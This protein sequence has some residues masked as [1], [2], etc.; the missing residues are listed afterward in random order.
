MRTPTL[1]QIEALMAFVEAGTVSRAA[2]ALRISQPAASKLLITLE[3]DTQLQLFE[4]E[5]R[6]LTLTPQ[7]MQLYQEIHRVFA[8]VEQIARAVDA[9]RQ[10]ERGRLLIGVMPALSGSLIRRALA[11]FLARH[12][13]VYV[14]VTERSSHFISD[15]VNRRQLDVG[16]VSRNTDEVS[17]QSEDFSVQPLVCVVPIGHHLASRVSV[18]PSDLKGE[19][20]IAF[21]PNSVIR[22]QVEKMLEENGI[23]LDVALDATTAKSV[24]E[25]VAA[26]M[27]IAVVHPLTI[28][29]HLRDKI[30]VVQL[31]PSSP[32]G[33]Q[34]CRPRESRNT[35]L[36]DAFCDEVKKAAADS[37]PSL[38]VSCR[39][40]QT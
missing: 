1:R 10:E 22:V 2:D 29:E 39:A 37:L 28:A 6:R 40:V 12:P 32:F 15:W 25:F 4:R 7:G 3:T 14:S 26:G 36:V 24:C 35:V 34:L 13:D 11:G 21:S 23:I 30:S 20:F 19:R 31:K 38:L 17:V 8:G 16:I 18:A 27:G 33:F 9:I 5:G